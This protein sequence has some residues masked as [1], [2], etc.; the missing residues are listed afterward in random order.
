M[1]DAWDETDGEAERLRP[2]LRPLRKGERP[3]YDADA[4]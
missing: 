4:T 2:G 1:Q 3:P